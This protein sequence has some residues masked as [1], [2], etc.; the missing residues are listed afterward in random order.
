MAKQYPRLEVLARL[1]GQV[2]KGKALLLFGAGTGL[3][4][5]C[6][7]RGGADLICVYSTARCRMSGR[8]SLLA[9]L[10]YGDC[11]QTTFEMAAEILPVVKEAPC[12][13]GL[14]AHDPTLDLDELVEEALAHGFSGITNE[15]FAGMYGQAF[16]EEL[17]R[18]G[19]GFSR[20][21][22]LIR[23]ARRR[24]AFTLAWAFT[25]EEGRKMAEAGADVIGAMIGVTFGGFTGA[26][27]TASLEEAIVRIG[28]ICGAVGEVNPDAL[29]VTHGGPIKDLESAER[30]IR[31]TSAVGYVA[32]SSGER[33]PTETAIV[34]LTK[35]FKDID[36]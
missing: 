29:V 21:V 7:E 16:G 15:P 20:E 35:R 9:W 30:S 28:E 13:A 19:M 12:I 33:I 11:N 26:G 5:K 2:E 25:A 34:E 18:A 14:G 32:G 17:E 6:A 23:T 10:P 3:T 36:A 24:D 27:K 31:Q 4:A 1:E 22:E 8:P